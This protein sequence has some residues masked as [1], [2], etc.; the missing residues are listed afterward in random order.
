MKRRRAFFSGAFRERLRNAW[1]EMREN[2]TRS[3]LQSL[4]VVLGVASVLGGFSIS[5]S[6][7]RRSNERYVR[8]GGLDKLNVQPLAP[9]QDG[10]APSALQTA[11]LGLRQHDA[12]E[13]GEL[14]TK[15]LDG[16]AVQKFAKA[17]VRSAFADR[18][19]DIRG[20][21]GDF[22]ATDGYQIAEGRNFT[23]EDMERGTP[24]A[25]LGSEAVQSFFPDGNA[26]GKVLRIGDVPVRVVGVLKERVFYFRKEGNNVFRW[27]NRIIAVP[28]TLVTR[29]F[30]GDQY[31]RLDRVTF[32]IRDMDAMAMF[33]KELS[34]LLK[35][36]HRQQDDFRLD[37]VRARIRKQQEQGDGYD[38]IFMLS[39]ILSLLGGGMVNVNVQMATLK[40]RIREVG[41]KMAIGAS[42]KEVFKEFMTEAL[43]LTTVG[44]TVGLLLGVGFSKA[45][46]LI[47]GVPLY[48]DPKSF[49]LAFLLAA[50]FGFLFALYPA[51]KASRLAPM[52]ALRYE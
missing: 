16:V 5:D 17:R 39:G 49:L 47:L 40:E 35:A 51:F 27:R 44:G 2:L 11:N 10:T 48:M 14:D 50:A 37:D 9:V 30:E 25:I 41:V 24:V 3:T 15:A 8:M 18:E 22:L 20:I 38:I 12:D 29:R 52:E 46:T 36:N 31:R 1:D 34:A 23:A 28:T 42:G 32:R 43:V 45:I 33:S 19:R 13:G 4:G 21:G 26:L 6:M 7:R